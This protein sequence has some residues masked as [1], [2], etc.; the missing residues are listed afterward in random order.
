[1]LLIEKNVIY[2]LCITSLLLNGFEIYASDNCFGLY[3]KNI[4]VDESHWA[5]DY[6]YS[7]KALGVLEYVFDVSRRKEA[8]SIYY[9]FRK[10]SCA[11]V[12]LAYARENIRNIGI[13]YN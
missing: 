2:L 1:M 11:G 13:S 8:S 7:I 6:V 3:N 4:A 9:I 12:L 10:V 5:S